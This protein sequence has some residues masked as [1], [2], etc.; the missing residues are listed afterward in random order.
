MVDCVGRG[1]TGR[2]Y[3][4]R[5]YSAAGSFDDELDLAAPIFTVLMV[6]PVAECVSLGWL[7]QWWSVYPWG[8]VLSQLR[9]LRVKYVLV[10]SLTCL[11]CE[12]GM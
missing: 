6:A 4:Y 3:L 7:R 12:S 10:A 2:L 1:R 9:W 8:R 5:Y 11:S